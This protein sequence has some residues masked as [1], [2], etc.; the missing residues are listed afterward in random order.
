MRI[1]ETISGLERNKSGGVLTIGNF[2][3]VHLGHQQIIQFARQAAVERGVALT[4]MTFEPHPVAILHPEKAPGVL[5]PLELKKQLLAEH[6]VD[7][8]IV[9]KDSFELL[10]LSPQ[11]FVDEFLAS[12]E[13][14]FRE[15][16]VLS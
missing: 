6:G 8:L 1:I 10:D 14:F 4:V 16:K 15:R 11:K 7:C 5:T 12:D 3:G 2:D 9:L 13:L